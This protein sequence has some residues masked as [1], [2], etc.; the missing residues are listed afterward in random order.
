MDSK[1]YYQNNKHKKRSY[2]KNYDK[3]NQ[4]KTEYYKQ[5]REKNRDE[6]NQY[7]RQYRLK[8]LSKVIKPTTEGTAIQKKIDTAKSIIKIIHSTPNNKIIV[9]FE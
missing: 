1:Q 6:Y 7:Y 4:Y 3:I 8:K 5:Y 9:Y 2:I